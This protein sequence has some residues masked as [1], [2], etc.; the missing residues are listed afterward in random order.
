MTTSDLCLYHDVLYCSVIIYPRLGPPMA[1]PSNIAYHLHDVPI[2]P[3][4]TL[5]DSTTP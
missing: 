2:D 1:F 4:F 5:Q 3:L